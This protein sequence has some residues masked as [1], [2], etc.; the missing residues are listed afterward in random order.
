MRACCSAIQLVAGSDCW[1][2]IGKRA[3]F[4]IVASSAEHQMRYLR[5]VVV[6]AHVSCLV[7]DSKLV[8]RWQPIQSFA[9]SQVVLQQGQRLL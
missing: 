4:K 1:R 9:S 5:L 3:K 7:H 6:P 2:F 8:K